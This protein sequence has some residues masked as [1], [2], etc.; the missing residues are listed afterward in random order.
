MLSLAE[1]Q[2]QKIVQGLGGAFGG[3]VQE[4][5][6]YRAPGGAGQAGDFRQPGHA[7]GHVAK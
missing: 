6:V 7:A 3:A 1:A 4:R 5:E 2:A